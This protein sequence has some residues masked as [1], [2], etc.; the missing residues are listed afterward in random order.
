MSPRRDLASAAAEPS[1][2]PA[3]VR[4]EPPIET[5][6]KAPYPISTDPDASPATTGS[7]IRSTRR[8]G[9]T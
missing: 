8:I 1:T 4:P 6:R 3:K 2:T 5:P 9:M 7:A